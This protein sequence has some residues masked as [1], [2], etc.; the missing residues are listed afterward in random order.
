[1]PKVFTINTNNFSY[2]GQLLTVSHFGIIQTGFGRPINFESDFAYMNGGNIRWPGGNLAEVQTD[3]YGL[4]IP[5][6]FDG[7]QMWTPDPDRHRSDLTEM[8]SA[9]NSSD[10]GFTMIIPTARYAQ[11][12]EIGKLHLGQL[13]SDI[14]DGVYGPIPKEFTLEIGNE[15]YAQAEFQNNVSLYGEIANEFVGVISEFVDSNP[16]ELADTLQVSI[17]LGRSQEEDELIR[18]EIDPGNISNI[19]ILVAH[20]LPYRFEAVDAEQYSFETGGETR[21]L[22]R[23]ELIRLQLALWQAKLDAEGDAGKQLQYNLSGWSMGT[24]NQ[25]NQIDLRFQDIGARQASGVLELFATHVGIGASATDLWGVNVRNRNSFSH[26]VEGESFFSA[27]GEVFRLM[28]ESLKGSRL[29]DGYQKNDRS[30]PFSVYSFRDLDTVTIFVA[31]NDIPDTG[32][33]LDLKIDG[34]GSNFSAT[35]NRLGNT[36]SMDTILDAS[37][38]A[39]RLFDTPTLSSLPG[40][41]AGDV[42]NIN[43]T[44]DYEIFRIIIEHD[45]PERAV[46]DFFDFSTADEVIGGSND[47]ILLATLGKNLFVGSSGNDLLIGGVEGDF[48]Q[49]GSGDDILI[50]DI[51]QKFYSNDILQPGLGNDF[52]TGGGGKD[53]FVFRPN[54]GINTI[55]ELDFSTILSGQAVAIG[56]DFEIAQDHLFFIGF[57]YA[58]FSE[59]LEN[60]NDGAAGFAVFYDQGTEINFFGLTTAEIQSMEGLFI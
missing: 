23:P 16:G 6:I 3:V 35:V 26:Q 19:D 20:Q 11:N 40:N 27:G 30:D 5:G 36:N 51:S 9:A 15:Y 33:E 54:E 13:L 50:G 55:A 42:L 24:G 34:F 56:V 31:A 28:A 47:D 45:N 10:V 44:Q 60:I 37:D 21:T 8:F 12:I 4:D 48:L 43:L 38:P 58:S 29:I 46:V 25:V 59:A 14:L 22:A 7:T 2:S 32:Y 39:L 18:A 52:L 49:G 57:D 53:T 17:Q 1:M 41:V